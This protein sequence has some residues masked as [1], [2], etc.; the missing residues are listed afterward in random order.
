MR[1]KEL[2]PLLQKVM[3]PFFDNLRDV[4]QIASFEFASICNVQRIKPEFGYAAIAF[5]MDVRWFLPIA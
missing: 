5:N 1:D 4:A 3:P 2:I